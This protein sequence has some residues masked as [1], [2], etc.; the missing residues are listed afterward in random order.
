MKHFFLSILIAL[1]CG[2]GVYA[3]ADGDILSGP[4][5]RV[6]LSEPGTLGDILPLETLRNADY[7]AISGP[8][9][10]TDCLIFRNVYPLVPSDE[11]KGPSVI[12][13]SGAKFENDCL[14]EAAFECVGQGLYNRPSEIVLP[15]NLKTIGKWAFAIC[16]AKVINLPP[17]LEY[18]E[19]HAFYQSRIA[20]TITIPDKVKQI[21]ADAFQNTK[22]L[23]YV[24][25][26]K[27]IRVIG[28]RAFFGSGLQ[29]IN[30]P[31]NLRKIGG[32]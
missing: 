10:Y 8:M 5:I 23:F 14:P 24:T 9:N 27:G 13:L 19:D 26:P 7:V 16:N 28:D 17:S 2:G 18:I 29:T 4:Y 12:D 1:M 20:G 11:Y 3:Q 21:S 22:H 31:S 30:L 15:E 6:T 25:L 32:G